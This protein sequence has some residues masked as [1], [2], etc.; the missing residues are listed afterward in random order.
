MR[1]SNS[2]QAPIFREEKRR[3]DVSREKKNS[4]SPFLSS[5]SSGEAPVGTFPRTCFCSP[6]C[7][8]MAPAGPSFS[9]GIKRGWGGG[10]THN[11]RKPAEGPFFS[12]LTGNG[13]GRSGEK[14]PTRESLDEKKVATHKVKVW[15]YEWRQ[16]LQPGI[17]LLFRLRHSR[18]AFSHQNFDI[19]LK[20]LP[21][22]L[23]LH[24]APVR[25]CHPQ[26]AAAEMPPLFRTVDGW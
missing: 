6:G 20:N 1:P 25:R 9:W 10:G 16:R 7:V 8:D 21:F 19:P 17:S 18:H 13:R 24:C 14:V 2:K 4:V 23:F 26:P 3:V 12:S 11:K 5:S 22:P 15:W